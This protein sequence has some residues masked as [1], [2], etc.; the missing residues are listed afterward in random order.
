[1]DNVKE[2]LN[3]FYNT[4]EEERRFD[5]SNHNKLE[6]IT[7]IKYIEKYLKREDKILEIGAG[8][9]AYSLHYAEN[10]YDVTAV[11]LIEENI[12]K[13]K[14]G[15]KENMHITV[16]QGNAVDLSFLKDDSFDITLVLGPMYHLFTKE[17]QEKAIQE[18]IRVT[19]KGG[20][21]YFAYITND[22]VILR[23]LLME[24]KLLEYKDK[25][26]ANFKLM[27]SPEE[28]FNLFLVKDF[29]K[30]MEATNTIC[31]HEVAT[32]GIAQA[33]QIYIDKLSEE[34]F[35]E[36]IK[37]HLANCERKDLI[38]YSSHVLH[39]CQKK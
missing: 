25:H 13:L 24:N 36:W 33:M 7:T 18:A 9:G 26:D 29:E 6:F 38:G 32:D 10:G 17:E 28:I 21:I 11:E 39:I 15:I 16:H 14:Q 5:K 8:T 35:E 20:Y 34:E 3:K 1:M 19:K 31:L 2:I 12:R 4:Y 23:C 27:N 22:A 37:Y 30:M